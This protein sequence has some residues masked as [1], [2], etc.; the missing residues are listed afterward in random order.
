MLRPARQNTLTPNALDN[1]RAH[2]VGK[3]IGELL[4]MRQPRQ[5]TL[6]GIIV[7]II[8]TLPISIIAL[9]Q[10]RKANGHAGRSATAA[11]EAN[12]H[13]ERSATARTGCRCLTGTDRDP[14]GAEPPR[15]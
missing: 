4:S 7:G 3:G 13:A 15:G 10:S 12:T 8:V 9:V 14:T 5:V 6:V 1:F 2:L 11:E